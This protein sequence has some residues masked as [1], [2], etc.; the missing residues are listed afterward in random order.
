MILELFFKH[1]IYKK[2]KRLFI[3][4]AVAALLTACGHRAS[5]GNATG[6]DSVSTDSVVPFA[7]DSIGLMREDTAVSVKVSV[8]WPKGSNKALVTSIRKYIC[9][10]LAA[11]L[12][13]EGQ[14][15]VILY[16]DGKKAVD[17]T[18]TQQYNDL[19]AGYREAKANGG[20]FDGM[21]FSYQLR[22][23]RL[24]DTDT[25]VTYLCNTEGFQGGAHGYATASGITF[26]K[27][28]GKRI[29]YR[30]V[31]NRQTEEFEIQEQTLFSNPR[32]S[33][34]A[35]LIKEGVRSYFQEFQDSTVTDK[36]LLD[37]L[38]GVNH[39]DSIP[40]P[41]TPPHFT[42]QG[43]CFIYQQ[44]EIAPYAA[45]IINFDLPYSKVRSCLTKDAAE[46]IK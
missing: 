14:P 44:Y 31:F 30:T 9:E 33:Q 37:D 15:N 43:L 25:Y 16:D 29:G 19:L 12:T 10:E 42:K 41:S 1:Y 39:V 36:Q 4:I 6:A 17:T 46:L 22:I 28:D 40:L 32:S 8:H 21:Q 18:A 34:L 26:R 45:G 3:P 11:G 2:V 5:T 35:A 24:E 23:T 13:Q 38:I 27:S 7:T 20:L